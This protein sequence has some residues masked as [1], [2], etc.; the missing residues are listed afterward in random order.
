MSFQIMVQR[1]GLTT[2][3]EE[4]VAYTDATHSQML[5]AEYMPEMDVG[6]P[7]RWSARRIRDLRLFAHL[8]VSYTRFHRDWRAS[9]I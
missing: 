9:F 7:H 4:S 6:T 5:A 3:F 2:E 1:G 8:R